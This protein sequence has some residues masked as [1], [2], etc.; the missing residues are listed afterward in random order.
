MRRLI[1][2]VNEFLLSLCELCMVVMVVIILMQIASRGFVGRSFMWTEEMAR[3]LFIFIVVMGGAVIFGRGSHIMVDLIYVRVGY[4]GKN[5]LT[6]FGSLCSV[7]VACVFVVKGAE[8]A[9]RTMVQ[10]SPSLLIPM[11]YV[12]AMFPVAGVVM[13]ANIFMYTFDYLRNSAEKK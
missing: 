5:A 13:L 8:L 4:V 9:R 12:Y 3:Y 6:I 10:T 1:S 11:G 2:S 7:A